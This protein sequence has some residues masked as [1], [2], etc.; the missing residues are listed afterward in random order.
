MKKLFLGLIL[1]LMMSGCFSFSA[2]QTAETLPEDTVEWGEG[3]GYYMFD[4]KD[5]EYDDET[6]E[7]KKVTKSTSLPYFPETIF[8]FGLAENMD[9][10]IKIYGGIGIEGD[11]KFRILSIGD[12]TSNFS[13]AL[14]PSAAGITIGELTIYKFSAGMIVSKRVNKRFALYGNFKY[15]YW[16]ITLEDDSED[17]EDDMEFLEN[18]NLYSTTV[19]LSIE[20]KKFWLRPELTVTLNKDFEKLFLLPALGFGLRF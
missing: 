2:H 16:G 6:G 7:D 4:Y 9:A 13:V 10:G 19:G 15:N 12:E 18:G 3:I 20:G 11:M 5:Y 1:T 8:R 14:Q 17:G